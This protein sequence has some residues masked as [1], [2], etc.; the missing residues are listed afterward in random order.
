MLS[1]GG[2][3]VKTAANVRA[4]RR[5]GVV[6]F[7]DRPVEK[8]R[9]GGSRPLSTDREALERMAAQRGPLYRAAADITVDNSGEP[10][11][12][13]AAAAKEAICAYFGIERP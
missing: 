13:A 10:F 8:L 6:L 3:V 5:N 12:R 11:A 9:V 1:C 2:G 4:L 7:I